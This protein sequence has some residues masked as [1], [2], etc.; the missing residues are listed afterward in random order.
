MTELDNWFDKA[1]SAETYISNMEKH[2][3]NLENVFNNFAIPDDENFFRRLENKN[4]RA[5]VITEDWCGDAMMNTPVLLHLAK[6]SHMEVRM[7]LRDDNLELMDQYLTNGKSRSIPIIIFI[8]QNGEEVTH[9]GPRSGFVQEEVDAIMSG[10]PDKE[11]PGYKDKFT[12]KISTLTA[13]F[14]TEA[15]LWQSAYRS[16][17]QELEA[18]I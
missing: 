6:K 12:K 8:D 4:L 7:L 17:K 13:R 2:K 11:A 18:N 9:W 1:M 3:E 5:I 10:L 15:E 16:M 14:S